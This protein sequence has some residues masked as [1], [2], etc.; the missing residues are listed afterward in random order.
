MESSRGRCGLKVTSAQ[1]GV[2]HLGPVSVT[3]DL[4]VWV[5]LISNSHNPPGYRLGPLC[6][7]LYIQPSQK[8]LERTWHETLLY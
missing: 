2:C 7:H 8:N 5:Y 4:S 3:S 1:T 6:P